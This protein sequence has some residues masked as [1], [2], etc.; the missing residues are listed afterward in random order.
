MIGSVFVDPRPALSISTDVL[1]TRARARR[2]RKD[3]EGD[4]T[5]ARSTQI[6]SHSGPSVLFSLCRSKFHFLIS[7]SLRPNKALFFFEHIAHRTDTWALSLF[8]VLSR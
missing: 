8:S 4:G 1:L 3:R 6:L 5:A 7:P 2:T